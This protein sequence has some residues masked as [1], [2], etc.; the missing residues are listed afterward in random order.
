MQA[1]LRAVPT[2]PPFVKSAAHAREWLA[3]V[4][5]EGREGREVWVA[6]VDGG[7]IVGFLLLEG[8]WIGQLYLEPS[9]TGRG[10]G[11]RL[12]EVAKRCRPEGLQLWT[13]QSNRGAHRF[14]ERHGFV[15]EERT[16]GQDNMERA[17]DV[18]YVW[19]LAAKG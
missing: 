14:Y 10:I 19:R 16:D 6:E 17:P 7:P 9:W 12:V 13:F 2:I 5:R 15:A 8:G 3:G 18:R 11:G 4:V 1:R